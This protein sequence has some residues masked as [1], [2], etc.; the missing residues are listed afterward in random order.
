MWLPTTDY[1]KRQK[2]ASHSLSGPPRIEMEFRGTYK[3]WVII[4]LIMGNYDFRT[5]TNHVVINAK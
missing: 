5:V 2:N 3:S 1:K 4:F